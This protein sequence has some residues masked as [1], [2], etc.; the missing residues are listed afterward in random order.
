VTRPPIILKPHEDEAVPDFDIDRREA[1]RRHVERRIIGLH[2][3]AREPPVKLIGPGM[4]RADQL[5]RA[6]RRPFDQ[7]HRTVTT[8]IGEG[9]H[10]PVLATHRDHAFAD[11]IER[12]IIARI[13]DVADMADDLP[14]RPDHARDLDVEIFG[15][16]IEPAREAPIGIR[17]VIADNVHLAMRHAASIACCTIV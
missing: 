7:S 11:K 14:R 5:L 8:D 13:G 12:V 16:G 17:I 2:R 3:Y 4:I 9:A 6:S 15:I 1:V 10:L